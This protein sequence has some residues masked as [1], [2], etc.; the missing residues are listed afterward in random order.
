VVEL[1]GTIDRAHADLVKRLP[2]TLILHGSEHA[3]LPVQN[4]YNLEKLAAHL[5]VTHEIKIYKGEEY[6]LG[7]VSQAGAAARAVRF[8]QKHLAK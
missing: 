7:S 2:P 6:V 4:A 5:G 1:A 8:F 3:R